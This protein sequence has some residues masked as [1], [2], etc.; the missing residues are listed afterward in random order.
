MWRWASAPWR[1]AMP[2]RRAEIAL[3]AR[4]SWIWTADAE[5]RWRRAL[6]LLLVAGTSR[7]AIRKEAQDGDGGSVCAGLDRSTG[8]EPDH[9]AAGAAAVRLRPAAGMAVAQPADLPR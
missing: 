7:V 4:R 8:R 3:A 9:R 5:W 2:R 1:C 6:R